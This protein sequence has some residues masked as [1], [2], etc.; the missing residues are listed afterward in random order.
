MTLYYSTV[1]CILSIFDCFRFDELDR[2]D[3]NNDLRLNVIELDESFVLERTLSAWLSCRVL[4]SSLDVSMIGGFSAVVSDDC[5]TKPNEL[6]NCFSLPTDVAVFDSSENVEL[7]LV[8]REGLD[9]LV[10]V[11]EDGDVWW[12]FDF[13]LSSS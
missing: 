10:T 11:G 6:N 13:G 12:E 8:D 1:F 9:F 7:P 4:I 5:W 3:E 2:S